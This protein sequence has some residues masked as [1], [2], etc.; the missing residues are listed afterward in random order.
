MSALARALSVVNRNRIY[1][2]IGLELSLE[3]LH[4]VQL[5]RRG[6]SLAVNAYAS[7][8]YGT[9]LPALLA[10]HRLFA[11]LV[12][13]ALKQGG[14]SGRNAVAAMPAS[15]TQVMPVSYQSSGSGGDDAAIARLMQERIGDGIAEFVI[16][17]MP[18]QTLYE[19]RE[20]LALVAICREETAVNFLELL[21]KAGLSIRALEI[22]PI[23]IR[24]LIAAVQRVSPPQNT[25]VVNCG[26]EKSYLTLVSDDRL[27]ADDEIDFGEEVILQSVC[28][29]LD[30]TREMA[31]D[32]VYRVDLDPERQDP[33][34]ETARNADSL[35]EII[36]PRLARLVQEI[37][38]G[39]MFAQSESRGTRANQIY[40]LGSIA[41]WP[42]TASLLASLVETPVTTVPSPLA[43]FPPDGVKPS[44]EP[45]PELAVATG[46]AL[47]KFIGND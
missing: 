44:A 3:Q 19:G 4:M 27:L 16:D 37:Q 29:A 12:K 39:L 13:Q 20:K 8:P 23:A 34:P 32:L 41:R 6:E 15:Q 7:V 31:E 18:V 38:R 25:L 14:F 35:T 42:G 47:R 43:L 22:G 17:Y 36:K 33:D 10:D 1:G 40:L 46:L 21:R 45:A 2:E 11:R 24:R 26:R 30:T 5:C 9:D 28:S